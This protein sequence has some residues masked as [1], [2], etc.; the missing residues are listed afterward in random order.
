[1]GLRALERRIAQVCRRIA[2]RRAEGDTRPV[3]VTARNVG[4]FLGTPPS[5]PEHALTEDRIGVATGL[6]VTSAGGDVLFVEALVVPGSG[7]ITLTGSLG[8]VMKESA[9]AALSF[10]RSRATELGLSP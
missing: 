10:L 9:T 4:R 2:R 7:H 3:Q 1:A 6:A 5:L 8:D